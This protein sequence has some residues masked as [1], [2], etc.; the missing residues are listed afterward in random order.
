VAAGDDP[1]EHADR[2]PDRQ[3]T[4]AAVLPRFREGETLE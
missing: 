4:H 3:R 1:H 2:D